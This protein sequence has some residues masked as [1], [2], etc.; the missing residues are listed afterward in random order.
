MLSLAAGFVLTVVSLVRTTGSSPPMAPCAGVGPGCVPGLV[1]RTPNSDIEGMRGFPSA[2][3][4]LQK[5]EDGNSS[6]E[7]YSASGI[8]INILIY[9]FIAFVFLYLVKKG[10]K[11]S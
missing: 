7:G 5:D 4:Y 9:A 10:K 1:A 2:M 11:E 3:L 8:V 6:Y